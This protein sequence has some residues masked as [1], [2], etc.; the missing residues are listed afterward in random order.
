MDKFVVIDQESKSSF[1]RELNE[2]HKRGYILVSWERVRV[3]KYT[4]KFNALMEIP[5]NKETNN[6][7]VNYE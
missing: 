5:D 4:C 7:E 6:S 3:S 1:Q 2:Y